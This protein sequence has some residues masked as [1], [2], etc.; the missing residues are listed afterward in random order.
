MTS[1]FFKNSGSRALQK[2]RSRADRKMML[3]A[4]KMLEEQKDTE[5]FPLFSVLATKGDAEAQ[6][7]VGKFYLAGQAV[8]YSLADGVYWVHLSAQQDFPP[9]CLTLAH[10]YK[11]GLPSSLD[12]SQHD[13]VL[14]ASLNDE[15][16]ANYEK[17]QFWAE[18]AAE[19][20]DVNAQAFLGSLLRKAAQAGQVKEEHQTQAVKW[21]QRSV[22]GGSVIGKLEHGRQILEDEGYLKPVETLAAPPLPTEIFYKAVCYLEEALEEGA[23]GAA[24]LLGWLRLHGP[25]TFRDI[26]KAISLLESVAEKGFSQAQYRLGLL[27]MQNYPGASADFKKAEK[28]LTQALRREVAPAGYTLGQLYEVILPE[29]KRDKVLAMKFYHA[30]AL[31]KDVPAILRLA[32]LLVEGIPERDIKPDL[33]KGAFWFS[34]ASGLGNQ[35]AQVEFG[36]LLLHGVSVPKEEGEAWREG[37]EQEAE[38]GS[39]ESAYNLALSYLD[40]IGGEKEEHLARKWLEKSATFFPEAAYQYGKMLFEGKGGERDLEKARY[41]FE[42]SAEAGQ[43]EGCLA[44][45][46]MYLLIEN[47]KDHPRALAL[48]HQ[49]AEAGS[50]DAMFS[51]GAMYGGGHD[52]P[53]DRF[54]ARYWFVLGAEKGN[55]L[56]QYMAGRYYLRSLGGERDLEKAYFWLSKAAE[57]GVKEAQENLSALQRELK[58]VKMRDK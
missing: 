57:K 1:L 5:A 13:Q 18:K 21:L 41:F 11:D 22:E 44:L 40:G 56:A 9:A 15:R 23:M 58:L 4:M 45:A 37:L 25:E 34:R 48:Y 27:Y 14:S 6:W 53:M 54:K 43:I 38:K 19:A 16:E 2:K 35:E 33:R 24:L 31:L 29:A 36:N 32:H 10:L 50:A 47:M 28:W 42:K 26:G 17:A 55:P 7:H 46:Q 30:A 3:R 49:A 8:P 51:L 12:L 39:H 52:V 20:G